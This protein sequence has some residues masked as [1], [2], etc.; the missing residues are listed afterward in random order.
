MRETGEK[1]ERAIKEKWRYKQGGRNKE[2]INRETRRG[3]E[4][5]SEEEI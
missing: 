5:K 4:R 1:R 3:E 2:R